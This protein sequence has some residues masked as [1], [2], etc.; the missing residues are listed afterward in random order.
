MRQVCPAR[1]L[2]PLGT[3]ET[4][5]ASG[6]IVESRRTGSARSPVRK[7]ERRIQLRGREWNVYRMRTVGV[8]VAGSDLDG[9]C[10]CRF[11]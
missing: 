7:F 4:A 5:P 1:R 9:G 10:V 6:G 3:S 8:R 2:L 11:Q